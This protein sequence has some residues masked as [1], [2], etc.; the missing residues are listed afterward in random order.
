MNNAPNVGNQP[1]FGHNNSVPSMLSLCH[2]NAELISL[3]AP[4]STGT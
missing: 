4:T 1:G 3:A 2:G